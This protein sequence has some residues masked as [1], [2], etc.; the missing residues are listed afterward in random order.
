MFNLKM[1]A[2][3]WIISF[4]ALNDCSNVIF[5]SQKISYQ[6]NSVECKI[7]EIASAEFKD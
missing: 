2:S 6:S 3:E 7:E 5:L 1:H 4:Y